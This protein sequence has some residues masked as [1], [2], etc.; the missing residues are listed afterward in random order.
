M[1]KLF[2]ACPTA[3]QDERGAA[4]LKFIIV[5]AL[6]ALVVYMAM[7][8]VPVAY[9]A[10]SY[11]KFMQD[12]VDKASMMAHSGDWVTSQLKASAGEYGVPPEAEIMT[13]P[14]DGR[15][16]TTVKFTRPIKLLP[17][18]TYQYNFEE[19]VKSTQSLSQ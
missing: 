4:R 7:Q 1:N 8:Y 6:T 10:Y 18:W 11:K 13:L 12:T 15:M 16:E 2:G 9:R 3:R 14:R 17:I 19:T 5:I